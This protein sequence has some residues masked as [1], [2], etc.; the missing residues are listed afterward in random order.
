ME[1]VYYIVRRR[2]IMEH[3]LNFSAQL[4][5][6]AF[7]GTFLGQ[8]ILYTTVHQLELKWRPSYDL[9]LLY[10]MDL[11]EPEVKLMLELELKYHGSGI[12]SATHD[13]VQR[14]TRTALRFFRRERERLA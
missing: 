9:E 7:S 8:T 11:A 5:D 4:G 3:F 6:G 13:I 1:L 10:C 14:F 2:M 12:Q